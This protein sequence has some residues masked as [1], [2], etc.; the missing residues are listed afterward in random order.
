MGKYRHILRLMD[1]LFQCCRKFHV[2]CLGKYNFG[3][4]GS[5]KAGKSKVFNPDLKGTPDIIFYKTFFAAMF[6]IK[7]CSTFAPF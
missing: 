5:Q 2:I 6:E 3:K 4:T 1:Q 7:S